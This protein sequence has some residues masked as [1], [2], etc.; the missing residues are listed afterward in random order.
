[1]CIMQS[2]DW[3]L[4]S[5]L[6]HLPLPPFPPY[7][8]FALPPSLP[9]SSSPS[10]STFSDYAIHAAPAVVAFSYPQ[11][12]FHPGGRERGRMEESRKGGRVEGRK[13]EREGCI[14]GY[15]VYTALAGIL[16][17]G[18]RCSSFQYPWYI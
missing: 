3:F 6:P 14:D 10:I 4:P 16:V 12:L 17:F 2:Y 13:G 18:H 8:S 1:M 7:P 9:P 11:N 15:K 5:S